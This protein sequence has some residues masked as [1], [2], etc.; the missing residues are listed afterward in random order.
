MTD[1]EEITK[2]V[3]ESENLLGQIADSTKSITIAGKTKAEWWAFFRVPFDPSNTNP[4]I[5]RYTLAQLGKSWYTASRGLSNAK[6]EHRHIKTIIEQ[7][8]YKV[9]KEIRK[10]NQHIGSGNLKEFSN[11]EIAELKPI[12]MEP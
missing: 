1:F 5:I 10:N 4:T 8:Q 12:L 3:I 6:A 11:M 7:K 9:K 2:Q